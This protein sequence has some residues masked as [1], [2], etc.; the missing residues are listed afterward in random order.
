M[1]TLSLAPIPGHVFLNAQ[2]AGKLLL[3]QLHHPYMPPLIQ[4]M[5][6][7]PTPTRGAAIIS[8]W[9]KLFLRDIFYRRDEMVFSDSKHR[10]S[11]MVRK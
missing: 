3:Y 8:S 2:F 6:N 9:A 1:V 5:L 4:A 10:L 7:A 11:L